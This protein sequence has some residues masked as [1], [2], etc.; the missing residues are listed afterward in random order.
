MC[1][2][3]SHYNSY[4]VSPYILYIFLIFFFHNS[5]SSVF[6]FWSFYYSK[7]EPYFF[8][9]FCLASPF[10][11]FLLYV[12]GDFLKF[13]DMTLYLINFDCLFNFQKLL[14]LF[15]LSKLLLTSSWC[16]VDT[17]S[18]LISLNILIILGNLLLPAKLHPIGFFLF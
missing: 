2:I 15:L 1:N 11:E 17:I 6:S 3:F 10:F 9:F 16:W 13:I 18:F 8:F 7:V 5:L 12:L 4:L 14:L